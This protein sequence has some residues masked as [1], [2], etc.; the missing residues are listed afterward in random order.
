ME[1]G[2]AQKSKD[3]SI[4]EPESLEMEAAQDGCESRVK[5]RSRKGEMVHMW[6]GMYQVATQAHGSTA[7]LEYLQTWMIGI[8]SVVMMK[9]LAC[10]PSCCSVSLREA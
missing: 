2:T 9:K 5:D 7:L 3:L 6:C 10:S 8:D 1:V 4:L